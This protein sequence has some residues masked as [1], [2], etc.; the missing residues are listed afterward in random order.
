MGGAAAAAPPA[1]G[2]KTSALTEPSR[3]RRA[4]GATAHDA[5]LAETLA[6]DRADARAPRGWGHCEDVDQIAYAEMASRICELQYTLDP[7]LPTPRRPTWKE[8]IYVKGCWKLKAYNSD[9]QMSTGVYQNARNGRCVLAVSGIHGTILGVE[10]T[11]ALLTSPPEKWKVCD[12]LMYAPFVKTWRRHTSLANWTRVT[13]FLASHCNSKVTITG[14]S[15][16]GATAEILAACASANQLA[17][18]QPPENPSFRVKDIHTYGAMASATTPLRNSSGGS[19]C[20]RGRRWFHAED[21]I[22]RFGP[23]FGLVHP[24]MDATEIFTGADGSL[25]FRD[26]DCQS[27]ESISDTALGKAVTLADMQDLSATGWIASHQLESYIKW[28]RYRLQ[29]GSGPGSDPI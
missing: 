25:T 13:N 7:S 26:Y 10:K 15:L 1:A 3:R 20:L 18:L 23:A 12:S 19:P 9:L 24:L 6:R 21:P 17:Q 11:F 22:A 2:L 8:A 16:G 5:S 4:A 27:A 14:Q 29:P 28:M